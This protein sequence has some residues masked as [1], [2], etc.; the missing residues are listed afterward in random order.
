[1]GKR[2]D[3]VLVGDFNHHDQHWGGNEITGRRQGEAGPI[4]DLMDEHGLLSLLLQGMKTW[5]G[6]GGKSTI[7]LMLVLAELAEEM[8]H[9]SIHPTE[10]RSD[11]RAIQT[12]F[13]LTMP[14]RMADLR[15]LFKNAL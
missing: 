2:M 3:I 9:C 7:N 14:K 1:M 8:V 11:H 13:D 15:L 6:P 12:E 4:I 5:E 10:H